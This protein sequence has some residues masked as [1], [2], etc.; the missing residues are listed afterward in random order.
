LNITPAT[1]YSL[2]SKGKIKKIEIS[3]A[4]K[5]GARPAIRTRK[6]EVDKYLG[7]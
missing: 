3:S 2:I 4:D 6:S 5:P 7:E 1:V